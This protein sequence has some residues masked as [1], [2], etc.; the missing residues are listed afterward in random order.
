[1]PMAA[2]SNVVNIIGRQ[3]ARH[4]RSHGRI[5]R[6]RRR[7]AGLTSDGA[8]T[9]RIVGSSSTITAMTRPLQSSTSR[10]RAGES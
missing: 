4:R 3:L 2:M 9:S 6:I 8:T 10:R 5:A 7:C 1:M